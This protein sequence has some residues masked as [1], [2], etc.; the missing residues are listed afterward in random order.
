[1][2]L[3]MLTNEKFT[4][5][6]QSLRETCNIGLSTK[7]LSFILMDYF[8]SWYGSYIWTQKVS[9]STSIIKMGLRKIKMMQSR[10]KRCELSKSDLSHCK[11]P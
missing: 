4:N 10:I 2:H 9:P 7:T 8:F 3:S 6:Q 1:M 11:I 5:N